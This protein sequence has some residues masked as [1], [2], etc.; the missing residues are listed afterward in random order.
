MVKRLDHARVLMYSHDTFGL[1]HL[2]R[3]RTIAHSLVENFHGISVLIISGSA[4][5]GAFDFR[6]RVDFVKIPSVIKLRNGE[7]TSLAGH[8]DI[9]DTIRM[10]ESIIRHTAETFN[11]DIFIVDKEPMG[12]HGEL[13]ETL[14][15]LKANNATL[16]LGLRDVMDSPRLLASEWARK[17]L[18]SKVDSTYDHIWVYGPENFYDPMTGM[19]IPT[20]MRERIQF[21]G[22]LKRQTSNNKRLKKKQRGDYLLVTTGGGG[23]GIDLID[24]VMSAYEQCS[25]LVHKTVVVLGPYMPSKERGQFLERGKKIENMKVIDF[26]SR[27]EELIFGARAVVSM[28]G[29]NTFCEILSFDKPALIVPRTVP[30]EE[31]LLRA[32]RAAELDMVDMLLPADADNPLKMANAMLVLL[33][34]DKPSIRSSAVKMEGLQNLSNSVE[35]IMQARKSKQ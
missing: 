34:R 31:Q 3:C 24:N 11:P 18:I 30:R 17:D 15:Y 7:Y 9:G 33:A 26:D 1:G 12:L 29:Y 2:R 8:I 16:V 5:A 14:T 10:R 23:D 21:V 20:S 27:L 32:Q 13:G 22:F 19:N 28:G 4:I 35:V 6:A 25:E